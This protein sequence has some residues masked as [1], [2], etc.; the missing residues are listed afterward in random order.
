MVRGARVWFVRRWYREYGV[1][2]KSGLCMYCLKHAAELECYGQGGPSKPR[3]ARPEC[4]GRH[5]IGAHRLLGEADACVN[6]TTGDGCES[7][8]DKEWWVNTVRAEEEG[9]DLEELEDPEPGEHGERA[10]RYYISPCTRKDDSG[11][12]D[13]LEYFG[14][15]QFPRTQTNG[16]RKDGGLRAPKSQAL[17][18]M[19]RRSGTSP[20]YSEPRPWRTTERREC[21]HPKEGLQQVPAAKITRSRRRIQ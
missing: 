5:A 1:L 18:R 3:C 17:R 7:D 11:L 13:E 14:M 20:V 15:L 10:D 9:E 8:E 4:G 6:L 2:E 12:E 21:P 16:K 19:R